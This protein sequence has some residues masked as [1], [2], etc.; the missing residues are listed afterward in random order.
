MKFRLADYLSE[1]ITDGTGFRA[2]VFCQ[3]CLRACPGCQ[4]P[5]THDPMGGKEADTEEII[6]KIMADPYLD[7][8][9]LSGGEP[10]LQP[11][12]AAVISEAVKAGGK[13]V[14]AFTG[15]TY[16]ELQ[17]GVEEGR[18]DWERLLKT[19]DVLVDG[20]F[21]LAE[22]SLELK[23]RGSRNQRILKLEGGAIAGR[24]D[25]PGK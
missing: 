22:K 18:K 21:L 12:P 23:F 8:V 19:I 14:W 11:E 20:P 10:F 24:L 16:E 13:N 17:K 2:V 3:G 4:N 1:S 5:Q 25:E 9:T 15:Y 7:G 6:K